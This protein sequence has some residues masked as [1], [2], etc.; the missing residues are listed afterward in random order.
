[1][2]QRIQSI[3]L[4]VAAALTFCLFV[5]PFAGFE[6]HFCVGN[7]IPYFNMTVCHTSPSFSFANRMLPLA[8]TTLCAA[9]LCL[10][11]IFLYSDRSRQMK[12][13]KLC[14]AIQAIVL[15]A[16][17]A[18]CLSIGNVGFSAKI[19]P[20]I[21]A[22]FPIVNIVLLLLAYRGIKADDDI[23]KSADRLR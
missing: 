17:V 21:A 18:Y 3:Y 14:I 16:M 22:V 13:V 7:N 19:N 6:F 5:I 10:I 9:L 8:I 23:V 20:K 15:I 1:M 11:A 4:F 12:V 2:I